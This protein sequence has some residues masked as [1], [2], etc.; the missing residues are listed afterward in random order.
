M[1]FVV[2]SLI[3]MDHLNII[4]WL[5]FSSILRVCFSIMILIAGKKLFGRLAG[6]IINFR[7]TK[8]ALTAG[9]GFLIFLV[10]Y[11]IVFFSGIQSIRGLS[12][13]LLI[14]H[15]LLL[16]ITTAFYEELSYRFLLLDGYFY[17]DTK[18]IKLK[19]FYALIGFI[20]FGA[21]H[22]VTDRNLYTFLQTGILGLSFAVIYLCT[23]NVTIPILLHFIYDIFANLAKYVQWNDSA[24]FTSLNSVF[25]I[26][27]GVLMIVSVVLLIRSNNHEL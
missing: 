15:I 8:A 7:N 20:C 5:I 24:L 2:I 18:S 22:V 6:D 27:L 10:Y 17:H 21:V 12:T 4:E 11:L 26:M 16:Q 13:S 25:E 3:V 1:V 9:C 14:T 23:R 19:L